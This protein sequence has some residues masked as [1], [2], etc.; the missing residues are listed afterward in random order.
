M[1]DGMPVATFFCMEVLGD[2]VGRIPL[3]QEEKNSR[4]QSG[5]QALKIF[6]LQVDIFQ[7]QKF[8][9]LNQR[10]LMAGLFQLLDDLLTLHALS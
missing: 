6:L 3:S 9:P 8:F 7:R 10:H 5:R 1:N 4:Q 2:V